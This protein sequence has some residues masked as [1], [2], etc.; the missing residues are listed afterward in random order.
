LP[1][2]RKALFQLSSE[3][4][5]E[6]SIEGTLEQLDVDALRGDDSIFELQRKYVD[7]Y[8]TKKNPHPFGQLRSPIRGKKLGGKTMLNY[9]LLESNVVLVTKKER[10]CLPCCI[11][12]TIDMVFKYL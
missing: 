4:A 12:F 5:H 3:E 9:Y 1:Y 10:N 2:K 11:L 8:S 7:L 6:L